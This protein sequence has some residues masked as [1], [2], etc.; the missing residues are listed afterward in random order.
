MDRYSTESAPTVE[1]FP[2]LEGLLDPE[3]LQKQRPQVVQRA[4]SA[5]ASVFRPLASPQ[6]ASLPFSR[7]SR[8]LS[9]QTESYDRASIM[10]PTAY[11][12]GLKGFAV[13]LAYWVHHE[14]WAH[15]NT[16]GQFLLENAYGYNNRY[17][18]ASFPFIRILFSG[19]HF[20][21]T[22]FFIISGFVLARKPLSL[23]HSK[24]TVAL[25]QHLV[26]SVFRRWFR[27][28]L[29]ALSITFLWMT[30]WH[31][32]RYRSSSPLA[33][34]P[35]KSYLSE[36]WKWY[37]DAKN[38]SFV[39]DTSGSTH[40]ND[41]LWSIPIAFRGSLV[42]WTSLLALAQCTTPIRLSLEA[43]LIWYFMYIVDGWYCSLFVMGML[44]CDIDLLHSANQLPNALR[45]GHTVRSWVYYLL[46]AFSLYLGGVPPA[47]G[48][49][50]RLKESPGWYML[51]YLRPQA[52]LDP[53]WFY[54]SVAA[55][56]ALI[57]IPRIPLLKSFFERAACQYL[58]R[59]A[60]A[61]YL[62]QG[63]ILWSI[64]DRVYAATGRMRESQIATVP[65]WINLFPFPRWGV[66]GLEVNFLVAHLILLPL[67][68]VA[69]EATTRI[70]EDRAKR[71][72]HFLFE[73]ATAGEHWD[74]KS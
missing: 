5:F 67:T 71:L 32:M 29:P 68:L 17:H 12:D 10:S 16:Q 69:A 4:K 66:M 9:G 42:V 54:C 26:S 52:A 21:A 27:L 43:G 72:S 14:M 34:L 74:E 57:S 49:A 39:F 58:G 64:G 44:I 24:S 65:G 13:L 46:L 31:L 30:S 33:G 15:E 1:K 40:Y 51:S 25:H 3:I 7:H 8:S 62:V 63:P 18:F 70:M 28:F 73:K 37:T 11:L 45:F 6:S 53:R 59:I 38:F 60:F 23:I 61:F 2:E 19:D 20:V 50:T 55:A 36:L 41:H 48:D 56:L 22:I 47:A 35:E